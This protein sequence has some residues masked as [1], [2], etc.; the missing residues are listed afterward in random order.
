MSVPTRLSLVRKSFLSARHGETDWN[1][2][3]LCL[4]QVDRPLSERGLHQAQELAERASGRGISVVFHSPLRRASDTASV[5][6]AQI[7][8]PARCKQ[9]LKE[10]CL[11]EKEGAFE[12][13][14]ADDFIA[15]WLDGALIPG[16]EPY[17]TFFHRVIEAVNRCLTA[18]PDGVALLVSHWGVQRALCDAA[19]VPPRDLD[20]CRLLQFKTVD[21]GWQVTA[22]A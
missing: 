18:A 3:N 14:P 11:G 4:G 17:P 8:V 13:D 19:E 6:A 9:G 15:A 5:I 16:A 1:S 7:D 20:H 12:G 22:G 21:A 2:M 10:A